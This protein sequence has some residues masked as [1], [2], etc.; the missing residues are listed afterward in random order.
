MGGVAGRKPMYEDIRGVDLS[1]VLEMVMDP[2]TSSLDSVEALLDCR[3]GTEP[4]TGVLT[5]VKTGRNSKSILMAL[6]V[7]LLQVC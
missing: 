4:M 2:S 6:V 3:S 7:S 5:R 1:L